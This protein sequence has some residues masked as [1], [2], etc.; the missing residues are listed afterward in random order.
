MKGR[1]DALS[2]YYFAANYPRFLNHFA[3]LRYRCAVAR[4]H[5]L[6]SISLRYGGRSRVAILGRI[7]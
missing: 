7:L 6:R 3:S 2:F 4:F 5:K 1:K